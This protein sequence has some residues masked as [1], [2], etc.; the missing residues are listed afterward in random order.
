MSLFLQSLPKAELHLHLEGSIEPETV[1]ELDPSLSLDAVREVYQY[2][3]F[4]GF[5]KS[6]IWVVRRLTEAQHYALIT[7]RLLESLQRQNVL[8]AEI[9]LSAGVILW[10]EQNLAEIYQAI[11]AEAEKSPVQVYWVFDAVRQFG[12]EHARIVAERAVEYAND[13]VVAFGIGGDEEHGPANWFKDVFAYTSRNGLRA[14]PHAGETVGPES[15]WDALDLGADR[16]GHGIAAVQDQTLMRHL[17]GH[18]IPLEVCISSNVCTGVVASL[19]DHP[20]RRLYDA[21]VPL[22]LNTDDPAMFHTTLNGE[23]EI[24]A[25]EF[26]F[27]EPE[28]RGLAE[29]SFRYAFKAAYRFGDNKITDE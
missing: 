14:V 16:I 20:V 13:G 6:Y 8:Y 24:A 12:V 29:N 10:K 25:R 27:T 22:I 15:I 7:R 3:G 1:V 18:G 9:T 5:L 21:G 17:S 26:G 4:P 11:R 19:R 23:Y 2:N 28:L